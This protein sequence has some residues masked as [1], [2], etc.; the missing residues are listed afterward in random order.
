MMTLVVN[1]ELAMRYQGQ[2]YLE[3][4]AGAGLTSGLFGNVAICRRDH[5]HTSSQQRTKN[6]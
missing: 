5:A 4:L 1:L 3:K 2:H 6:T